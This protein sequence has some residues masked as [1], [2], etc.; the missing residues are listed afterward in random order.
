M[1]CLFKEKL[2]MILTF[3]VLN[4]NYCEIDGHK[5]KENT[6]KWFTGSLNKIL[7]EHFIYN[8]DRNNS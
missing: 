7:I 3:G 6:E 5:R 1:G 8:I 4:E 2:D